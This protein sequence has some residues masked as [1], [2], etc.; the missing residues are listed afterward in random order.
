MAT[1]MTAVM[2]VPFNMPSTKKRT[3]SPDVDGLLSKR[4]SWSNQ[5]Y[6]NVLVKRHWS[7]P[8]DD[9]IKALQKLECRRCWEVFQ[10]TGYKPNTARP[11]QFNTHV[12]CTSPAPVKSPLQPSP[13]PAVWH[14]PPSLPIGGDED[15]PESFNDYPVSPH[16]PLG[17]GL[18]TVS[19]G[20]DNRALSHQTQNHSDHTSAW[21]GRRNKQA[22]QWKSV[23][24]PQLMPAYLAYCAATESGRLPPQ[25]KLNHKCQCN[26]VALQ[27]EMVTWDHKFSP[28]F[29]Q[30][31]ANCDLHQD[32][33]C[34]YWIPA[35]VIQLEYS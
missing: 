25:P 32:P 16:A 31:F 8:K 27:V 1:V 12:H 9:R 26:K 4:Q 19:S 29:L 7:G 35:S 10:D 6:Q 15:G 24:I 30:L 11:P 18:R 20:Q 13:G 21:N 2:T 22:M 28:H 33:C 5:I 34:R 23:A 14:S 17:S 3:H